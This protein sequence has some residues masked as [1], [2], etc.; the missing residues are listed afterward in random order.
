VRL[1]SAQIKVL[2]WYG[3]NKKKNE[4]CDHLSGNGE[5]VA[6][7]SLLYSGAATG[8]RDGGK[9]LKASSVAARHCTVIA[10][11]TCSE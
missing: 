11:S 9:E 1:Q 5:R 6:V 2:Q 8:N 10:I 3:R 4:A 7:S